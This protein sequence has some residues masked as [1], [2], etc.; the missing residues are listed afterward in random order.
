M[1]YVSLCIKIKNLI[2]STLLLIKFSIV[3]NKD[4]FHGEVYEFLKFKL[5]LLLNN[6][7]NNFLFSLMFLNKQHF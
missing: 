5:L 6:N 4:R 7:N 2:S 3:I 1:W